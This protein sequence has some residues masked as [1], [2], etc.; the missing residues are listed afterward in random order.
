MAAT[1]THRDVNPAR[2]V[3]LGLSIARAHDWTNPEAPRALQGLALETAWLGTWFGGGKIEQTTAPDGSTLIRIQPAAP[4]S[5]ARGQIARSLFASFDRWVSVE[6][7]TADYETRSTPVETGMW[8]LI[9]AAVIIGIARCAAIGYAA[10]QAAQVVDRAL[11]RNADGA[12]LAESHAATL[13]VLRVHAEREQ[14]AGK[15]LDL[16][17]PS[18]AAL[19]QL[20]ADQKAIASKRENPI[21]SGVPESS[22]S[23]FGLG[24]GAAAALAAVALFLVH[25]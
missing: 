7:S 19:S 18:R 6:Q 2:S 8:P 10:Y 21:P 22:G 5:D 13:A 12:K 3:E 24:F 9:V 1:W 15:T 23:F 11:A 17:E 25:K 4:G 16:D 20:L 14:A